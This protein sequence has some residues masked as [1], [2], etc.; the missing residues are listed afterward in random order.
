VSQEAGLVRAIQE[1]PED[2]ATRLVYADWLKENGDPARAE[3]I[4]VQCELARGV[5][6]GPR[7][8]ILKTRERELCRANGPRWLGPLWSDITTRFERGMGSLLLSLREFHSKKVQQAAEW[9]ARG[10]VQHLHLSGQSRL[11]S[12]LADTPLLGRL[13]DLGLV[14]CTVRDDGLKGLAASPH[15]APL[16]TLSFKANHLGDEGLR[17]LTMSPSLSRLTTLRL[18]DLGLGVPAIRAILESPRLPELTTLLLSHHGRRPGQDFSALA[19]CRGLRRLRRLH[20]FANKIDP[21]GKL[22]LL[23]SGDLAGLTELALALNPG[24][25]PRPDLAWPTLTGTLALDNLQ[26]LDVSSCRL[27]PT[28]AGALLRAPGL[29]KLTELDLSWNFSHTS[30]AVAQLAVLPELERLT[31]LRLCGS[32]TD[33]GARALAASPHLCMLKT[34]D[35][36]FHCLTAAGIRDL[37]RSPNFPGLRFLHVG[38]SS[39][40]PM[41]EAVKALISA[42]RLD[43]LALLDLDGWKVDADAKAALRQRFGGRTLLCWNASSLD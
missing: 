40:E 12:S 8:V 26:R 36:S 28:V 1:K 6:D 37:V 15:V 18:D 2:D 25:N 13:H 16:R 27:S 39:P 33:D 21:A 10:G 9:F 4:R 19:G 22:V 43:R 35:L 17:A 29:P 23:C 5:E 11:T 20:L 14:C 7:L 42:P 3:L 38:R 31:T 24:L 30:A 34:L 41:A 32:L